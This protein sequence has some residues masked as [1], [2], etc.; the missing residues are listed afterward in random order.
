MKYRKK[1]NLVILIVLSAFFVIWTTLFININKRFP[2]S[3]LEMYGVNEN[4]G[5]NNLNISPV[6]VSIYTAKELKRIYPDD[7][8]DYDMDSN[9]ILAIFKVKISNNTD[10]DI[11][12]KLHPEI[13]ADTNPVVWYNGVHQVGNKITTIPANSKDVEVL[14]AGTMGESIVNRDYWNKEK[15]A[16][17]EY[18]LVFSYYPFKRCLTFNYS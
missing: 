12:F 11:K 16:K 18:H 7:I 10:Q 13:F 5:W 6:S 17:C 1:V 9:N 8:E 15:L 4:I 2:Q 3:K 14:L